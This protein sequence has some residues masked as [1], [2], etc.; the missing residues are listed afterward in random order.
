VLPFRE[1]PCL[2]SPFEN[3]LFYAD[4]P[5]YDD[6][7]NEVIRIANN[8]KKVVFSV[9]ANEIMNYVEEKLERA[10]FNVARTEQTERL[11][12]PKKIQYF[13]LHYDAVPLAFRAHFAILLSYIYK[14]KNLVL[15]NA[16]THIIKNPIIR[17]LSSCDEPFETCPFKSQCPF[18]NKHSQIQ[19]ADI[20]L[21][22]HQFI[23]KDTFFNDALASRNLIFLDAFR[24]PK[25]IYNSKIS[26][27][28]EELSMLSRFYSVKS[29]E[30]HLLKIIFDTFENTEMK[31]FSNG[32]ESLKKIFEKYKNNSLKDFFERDT[33]FIDRRGSRTSIVG[34]NE[35]PKKAFI[36]INE[37]YPSIA[38]FA[39]KNKISER[40]ILKEFT[41]IEGKFLTVGNPVEHK[42]VISIAPLYLPSSYNSTFVEEFLQFF[43]KVRR[44]TAKV[45]II[46]NQQTLLKEIY[47]SMKN[48]G[49]SPKAVGIDL[50]DES[51]EIEMFLYDHTPQN[52]YDEIYLVK[53]PSVQ[54]EN[55]V[56]ESYEY[57][58][59]LIARNVC[60]LIVSKNDNPKVVFYF[61]SKLKRTDYRTTFED[62]F[63]SFPLFFD[64]E[65]SIMRL[66]ETWSKRHHN[67]E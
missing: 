22:N 66:L 38:F 1:H 24:L 51:G 33:Y 14:T 9:Y 30:E 13:M 3:G 26:Y 48:R 45:A 59:A 18:F 50:I 35:T 44:A 7:I 8:G 57:F 11:L 5:S 27:S 62:L 56:N 61:D 2:P 58:S 29:E 65:E 41:G 64:R 47:F 63:V 49:L 60:E 17:V 55:Y 21:C 16:P 19:S 4:S 15:D 67:K 6:A 54:S 10:G 36:K 37:I 25:I 40:I 12:C 53:L 42:N 32:L 34:A 43:L 23:L 52:D 46:F 20:V 28:Y 39:M 31:D